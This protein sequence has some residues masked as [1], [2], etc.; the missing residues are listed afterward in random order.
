MLELVSPIN[1]RPSIS[2]GGADGPGSPFNGST[3]LSYGG[4]SASVESQLSGPADVSAAHKFFQP[5]GA[6]AAV[7]PN[8]A[9]GGETTALA[10]KAVGALP[11]VMPGADSAIAAAA[12]HAGIGAAA[13]GAAEISPL[14]QLIM[15]LPGA[16][17]VTASFFEW[18]QTLFMPT[19]I[20]DAF[21]PVHWAQLGAQI[22]ANL[23]GLTGHGLA[24][25]SEHLPISLSL[26][27]G[28]APIFHQMGLSHG[29]TFDGMSKGFS[30]NGLSQVNLRDQLNVSGTLDLK[31][32]QFEMG[33][34]ASRSGSLLRTDGVLS[35]PSLNTDITPS[36]LSGTERIFSD[37]IA[38]AQVG[39]GSSGVSSIVSST[40]TPVNGAVP[41]SSTQAT[42]HLNVGSSPFGQQEFAS[43]SAAYRLGDG[44]VSGPSMSGNIG[45]QLSGS[46]SASLD[47]APALSPSGAVSNQLGGQQLLAN[48]NIGAPTYR[49]SMGGYYNSAEP[50]SS[51][52]SGDAASAAGDSSSGIQPLKAEALSLVKKAK[53]MG[54]RPVMD[55]QGHQSKGG[56][57]HSHSSG[58]MDQVSH[59]TLARNGH[60]VHTH[61]SGGAVDQTAHTNTNAAPRPV[62]RAQ[63][64]VRIQQPQPA[65]Q[66]QV[67]NFQY[68]S[69][70]VE[71]QATSTSPENLATNQVGTDAVQNYTVRS[72]D[73]LWDI[74]KKHLGDGSRWTEIYH[75]NMDAVGSNPSLI[76]PGLELKMP[77]SDIAQATD[78]G[79]Y[80]VQPGDNLWDISQK[81]LG[82]GSRWGELYKANMDVVGDNPRLIFPGQTL[83]MPGQPVIGQNVLSADP[84]L[85]QGAANPMPAQ[86][87]AMAQPDPS[88]MQSSGYQQVAPQQ[89]SQAP[90]QQPIGGP[91]AAEA[92][93]LDP[94]QAPADD[95]AVSSTLAPDL[96]FL[97]TKQGK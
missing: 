65:A 96:S 83:Q 35:G 92:A 41:S 38:T 26:L 22:K 76:H 54:G 63:Q 69:Q 94:G 67:E 86:P 66:S 36:Q 75:L 27:P 19:S 12:G 37:K 44:M 20:M 59:R 50:V 24:L 77:G 31:K 64:Q 40:S 61:T 60:S 81:H 29:L 74:A 13:A 51:S 1:Y 87:T 46:G 17:G 16:M 23:S 32:P 55:Y 95:S 10:A 80:T 45:Y 30:A 11:G 6:E 58:A 89:V 88:S 84:G 97:Y 53:S 71:Q 8:I 93:T 49:P 34:S 4:L 42:S 70:P 73:N 39:G 3:E 62:T 9:P 28:N 25:P 18:L 57:Y 15:R 14:V 85:V 72:G 21:N 56:A 2:S 43:P 5:T 68:E 33:P 52:L 47:S 82:D 7:M 48:E 90:V 78:A 91:G 79:Q